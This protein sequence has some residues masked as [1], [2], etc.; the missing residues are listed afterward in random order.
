MMEVEVA[1]SATN[2]KPGKLMAI[3]LIEYERRK[4]IDMMIIDQSSLSFVL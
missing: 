3:I 4:A 1:R 2:A